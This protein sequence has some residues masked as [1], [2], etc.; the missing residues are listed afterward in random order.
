LALDDELLSHALE[1]GADGFP[2]WLRD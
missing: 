1:Q 2:L